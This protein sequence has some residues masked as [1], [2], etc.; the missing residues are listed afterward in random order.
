KPMKTKKLI[1]LSAI[2]FALI[3]AL[4]LLVGKIQ[5]KNTIVVSQNLTERTD[6][7][8]E[9]VLV[10]FGF[11]NNLEQEPSIVSIWE[12]GVTTIAQTF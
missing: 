8:I 2:T 1:S 9:N 10:T 7:D 3:L 12:V 4:P 6:A 5:L 11:K